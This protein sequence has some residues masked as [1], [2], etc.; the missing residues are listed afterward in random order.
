MIIYFWVLVYIFIEGSSDLWQPLQRNL[1]ILSVRKLYN[2]VK[3]IDIAALN[4]KRLG[5]VIAINIWL[6]GAS[7]LKKFHLLAIFEGI[8]QNFSE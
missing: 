2:G 4:F 8:F 7:F 5:N 1:S 6:L 3:C